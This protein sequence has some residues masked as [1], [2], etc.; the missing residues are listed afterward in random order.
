MRRL[1]AAPAD[2]LADA[3]HRLLLRLAGDPSVEGREIARRLPKDAAVV[4]ALLL[5]VGRDL[6]AHDPIR[7]LAWRV[8]HDDRLALPG[9]LMPRVPPEIDRDPLAM[10]LGALACGLALA[11]LVACLASAA[12]RVRGWLLGIAAAALVVAPT[13][14]LVAMGAATGR[15]Y[16]QDGGVVQLPLAIEKILSG[17]TPY[18]ADYSASMLGRQARVSDFWAERGGNPILRHHAYLPGTH[19]LMLPFHL[20]GRVTGGFDPRVVTLLALAAAAALAA[21]LAAGGEA[22]LI[23]AAVVLVNPLVYWQQIFGANDVVIVALL[24]LAVAVAKT[25]RPLAAAAVVGVAC[26]TKQLAWPFAP[27]VLVWLSGLTGWRELATPA[28]LRRVLV[29]VGVAIAVFAAIVLPVAALDFRRF[30]GDV[31]VYNV[32]LSGGDNYPLGGTPGFGFANLLIY[33]GKVAS[34]RDHVSFTSFYLLLVPV[35]L[36][37]AHRQLRENTAA[38]ALLGGGTALL[39]SLYFSRVVHPNYLILA[40]TLLPLALLMGARVAADVVVAPLLL[41]AI[42]VEVAEGAV[43]RAAWGDAVASR[44]P[45][46]LSGIAAALA[47]RAGTEL[48]VDPLGLLLSAVAAGLGIALLTVGVLRAGPRVRLALVLAAVAVVVLVPTVVAMRIARA[49][50]VYRAQHPWAVAVRGVPAREAWSNSFRRDPPREV[51]AVRGWPPAAPPL[52][53]VG[54]TRDPRL[55]PLVLMAGACV[56]SAFLVPGPLRPLAVAVTALTP[57]A[58]IGTHFGGGMLILATALL[59]ASALAS[60][61]RRVGTVIVSLEGFAL[62]LAFERGGG[63]GPANAALYFGRTAPPWVFVI[64]AALALAAAFAALRGRW[65]A[66]WLATAAAALLALLWF[67]PGVSPHEVAVPIA[68][69]A[70]AAM[71]RAGP[72]D[73]SVVP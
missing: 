71:Q 25:G 36:L 37:L 34:L 40:A 1:R 9:W 33:F 38:Q 54:G 31:V 48:T 10:A 24:L 3:E 23:A 43:F 69:A 59:G 51:E 46:H 73:R 57:A 41:L 42:A 6:L 53:A 49:S 8:L 64:L 63:I 4:P 44:L 26:A 13:L 70:I 5:L 61:K 52:R 15:P 21:R 22:R 14:G 29:P 17:E 35:G 50:G 16:G 2:L 45:A 11:Y 67:L 68:L 12:V 60:R 32:G 18:G 72:A 65:Q 62:A 27:F 30:W 56:L 28:G 55:V 20:L 19:A 47:P 39:L 58:A 7:V 66:G